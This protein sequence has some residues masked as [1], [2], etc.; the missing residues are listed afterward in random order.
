MN[1]G[2]RGQH[3]SNRDLNDAP[4]IVNR[5]AGEGLFGVFDAVAK[6]NRR[7]VYLIRERRTT[8][9]TTPAAFVRCQVIGRHPA[10]QDSLTVRYWDRGV[11]VCFRHSARCVEMP[12]AEES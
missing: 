3:V 6:V 4:T 11:L 1:G 12:L 8:K 7:F 10:E 5:K 9:A 2:P